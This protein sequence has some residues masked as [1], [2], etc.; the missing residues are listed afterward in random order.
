MEVL[1]M[2]HPHWEA[3]TD[4]TRNAFQLLSDIDIIQNFYLAGGTGLALHLGHRFSIDLDLFSEN[5]EAVN[6]VE[7]SRFREVLAH[8][9]FEIL[10]D[11]DTTFVG[12]WKKVGVSFFR[13]EQYPLIY[14]PHFLD[15]IKIASIADIGAMKLAAI[16]D[17][18]TRKDLVDLYYIL[19]HVPLEKVFQ[20]AA[21][22]Y[23]NFRSFPA[24]A[25]RGM[26]YFTDAEN[27]PMPKMIEK[28]SWVKMKKYLSDQA[29]QAG[30][31]HLENYW[32]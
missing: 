31:T 11:K 32:G 12:N 14:P 1:T 7:R 24:S 15:G 30:R 16:I 4:S 25:L 29:L 17:R 9:D 3:L 18:G 28:T 23:P 10:I 21:K 5:E 26:A 22:K 13:L 20:T 6:T 8:P 27:F 19:Q 2:D